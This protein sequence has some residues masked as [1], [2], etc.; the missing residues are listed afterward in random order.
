MSMVVLINKK[1]VWKAIFK[2]QRLN[3]YA[4]YRVLKRWILKIVI[5]LYRDVTNYN[6]IKIF[7]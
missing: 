7:F 1:F 3:V 4:C 6:L 2:I 5:V